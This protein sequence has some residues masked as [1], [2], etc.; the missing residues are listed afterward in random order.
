M[1]KRCVFSVKRLVPVCTDRVHQAVFIEVSL[2]V[3]RGERFLEEVPDL[4]D[5]KVKAGL[6]CAGFCHAC[7]NVTA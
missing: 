5:F 3:A 7:V 2:V 6:L 1:I 4:S